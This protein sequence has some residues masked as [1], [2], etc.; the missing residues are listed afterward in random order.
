M[1]GD[2]LCSFKRSFI[3]EIGGD[4]GRAG[5]VIADFGLD[6]GVGRAALNHGIG[7]LQPHFVLGEFA[8]HEPVEQHAQRGQILFGRG[9]RQR[10]FPGGPCPANP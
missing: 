6:A 2:V 9:H 3:F 10:F 8:D 1:I 7:V 5:S 4:A